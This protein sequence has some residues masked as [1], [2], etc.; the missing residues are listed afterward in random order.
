MTESTKNI[1]IFCAAFGAVFMWRRKANAAERTQD[2]ML[3]TQDKAF[4]VK[5]AEEIVAEQDAEFQV[6]AAEILA[7]QDAAF[8]GEGTFG[9]AGFH[10]DVSEILGS[11]GA[12]Y[13]Y[14]VDGAYAQCDRVTCG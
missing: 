9:V 11:G 6:T 1:L 3:K 13:R 10:G 14:A 4:Q 7:E 8:A 5:T 12:N 2:A